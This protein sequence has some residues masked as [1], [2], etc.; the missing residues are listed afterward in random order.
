MPISPLAKVVRKLSPKQRKWST[1]SQQTPKRVNRWFKWLSPGLFVK[2]W[3]LISAT[4]LL[5]SVLGLAIWVKLTPVNRLLEL[6][7]QL[8]ETITTHVPSYISGPLALLL[9]LFLLLWG[10]SRSPFKLSSFTSRSKNCG[11]WWRNGAIYPVTGLKA[12][13]C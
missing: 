9:G 2:R 11:Y 10:Q 1:L 6:I 8:L 3:L 4:G 5:L 13:Q 12:V 7:S